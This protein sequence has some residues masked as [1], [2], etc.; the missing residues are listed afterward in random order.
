MW[1]GDRGIAGPARIALAA[2]LLASACGQR[3]E[4][5]RRPATAPRNV[6]FIVIDALRADHVGALGYERATTP[7][8]DTLA[9]KSVLF[10]RAYSAASWTLPSVASFMTSLYPSVHGLRQ[11]PTAAVQF[12]LADQLLTLAESLAGHGFE[13]ASI[14]S[15]PWISERTGLTQGF[16]LVRTVA[17]ASLPG[18]PCLLAAELVEWLAQP[19]PKPFFLY[20]HFMG[21]H[22][23]YDVPSEFTGRYTAGRAVPAAVLEFH[24][25]SE[26]E[27][28]E[29]AHHLIVELAARSRLTEEDVR[30]L[31]DE[32]DEKL[33]FTDACL[34]PLFEA[35]EAGGLLDESVLVVTADH[36]EAF[37]EHG[38]IFHGEHLH[39]ELVRVPLI[40]HLPGDR[41]GRTK[42]DDLVE[43]IDLY[44]TLHELLGLPTPPNLQG[45]SLLPLFRGGRSDGLACAEGTDFK[46]VTRDWS[47]FYPYNDALRVS[48]D[49]HLTELYHLAVDPLERTNVAA[50]E[51][52]TAESL[53][54]LAFELWQEMF[55]MQLRHHV[56]P[57]A[58]DLSGVAE[59]RLRALGYLGPGK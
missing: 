34:G 33:A 10:T 42:I 31:I 32:Y 13:T 49:L 46:L 57:D 1:N 27:S 3:G 2:A 55:E 24:R 21:P 7:R 23:P 39:E 47:A 40:L 52:A 9:E 12:A 51:P 29:E 22:A 28:E 56:V 11:P 41:W 48:S 43:L 58:A 45:E 17:H 20:A 18:E 54:A 14:T 19:R 37:D 8:L 59:K 16:G 53:R 4:D 50:T 44:P 30:Y 15:Q 25:L 35:L 26:F 6:I 36:G 5:P 38:T